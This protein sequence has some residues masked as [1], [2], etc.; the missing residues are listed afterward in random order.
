[1][2]IEHP[3]R[4]NPDKIRS[5]RDLS[6][7]APGMVMIGGIWTDTTAPTREPLFPKEVVSQMQ[8]DIRQ[9]RKCQTQTQQL[10]RHL[11]WDY[12]KLMQGFSD[13]APD[14]VLKLRSLD[15]E[16][17]ERFAGIAFE[18]LV[19]LAMQYGGYKL[20]DDPEVLYKQGRNMLLFSQPDL[21]ILSFVDWLKRVDDESLNLFWIEESE[22]VIESQPLFSDEFLSCDSHRRFDFTDLQSEVI[23]VLHNKGKPFRMTNRQIKARLPQWAADR[24]E[25]VERTFEG[26][27]RDAIGTI[28]LKEKSDNGRNLYSLPP[29]YQVR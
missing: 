2:S 16:G 27:N 17:V 14:I 21:T 9:R 7:P 5:R 1:M 28:I 6:P 12:E 22:Q 11:I 26:K 4:P 8:L 10:I 23:A 18:Y 20:Q 19:F 13:Q 3:S 25:K 15:V 24:F 29:G